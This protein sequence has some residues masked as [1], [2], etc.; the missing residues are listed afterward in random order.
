M[1]K[2]IL[3]LFLLNFTAMNAT[4]QSPYTAVEQFNSEGRY[5]K[6]TL[7]MGNPV[8]IFVSSKELVRLDASNFKLEFRP[9]KGEGWQELKLNSYGEYY[10]A[11]TTVA[12]DS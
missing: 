8:Q 12:P 11:E 5:V 10:S 1:Q 2:T 7:L 4:A 6:V 9:R 3:F